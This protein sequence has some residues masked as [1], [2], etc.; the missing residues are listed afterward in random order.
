MI[1]V[2]EARIFVKA[3][4]GGRGCESHYRDKYMRHPRPDGGDGGPGG[5]VVITAD[6]SIGTLL[7]FRFQ[8]HHKAKNG[9]HASS[10]G[11]KGR[12]GQDCVLRVPVG[13][14]VRDADNGLV[15]QDLTRDGQIVIVAKGGA[16]GIGNM[17]RKVPLAPKPGDERTIRLELKVIADVGIVGFPNA[18]KSSLICRISKVKSRVANYPFTT[19]HP[20]LGFVDFEG[21]EFIVADLPG[22]IEGAHEG[23]G[24]GHRFLK[25][26]ERTKVL[27]H[28]I[29]MAGSEERDPLEDYEKLN[30][31]LD[32]YSEDLTYKRKLVV[33]N[34]MDLPRAAAHLRRFKKKYKVPVTA[35]SAETGQG[36]EELIQEIHK[37]LC[38]VNSPGP[39]NAWS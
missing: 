23:K 36:T 21:A 10:K 38:T 34:K 35:V 16:G 29:D 39:S 30:H 25:H 12:R 33:A 26:A 17:Q 20:V 1:F 11:K 5:D 7:D 24:L 28:L 8:Q 15:I 4:D 13:T 2:D 14:M 31:E 27:V 3:G 37:L 6:R 22:I 32:A 19:K 18:G 9:G